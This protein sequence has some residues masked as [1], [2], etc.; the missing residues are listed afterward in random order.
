MT[1][2]NSDRPGTG[3]RSGAGT[4]TGSESESGTGTGTGSE[5]ATVSGTTHAGEDTPRADG[6]PLSAEE[7]KAA[8][9]EAQKEEARA[10]LRALK[11]WEGRATRQDKALM[12]AFVGVPLF[13]MA[14]TPLKPFLIAHHPVLLEF[15]T[16]SN[17]AVGAAAAFARIG[18][19]PL[20]L[21]VVAGVVGK[22]KIDWLFWWVGRRWGR[23]FVNLIAPGDRAQRFADRAQ[24]MSPWIMPVAL[25]LSYLPGIPT[26]FVLVIAGWTGMRLVPFLLL[27]ALGA[28]VLTASVASVGYAAGQT[29]VDIVLLVDRYALWFTLGIVVV[30]AFVPVFKQ[31]RAQKRAKA[32]EEA[33]AGTARGDEGAQDPRD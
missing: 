5:S 23:G 4:G 13:F 30:M 28:L 21:V 26:V 8:E 25:V 32:A 14:L 33:G 2:L 6:A 31:N 18:E 1:T 3:A 19:I 15:V 20:W 9:R 29:G 10:A 7:R 24:D 17:A 16:G 11:P 12:A 22:V 27:D